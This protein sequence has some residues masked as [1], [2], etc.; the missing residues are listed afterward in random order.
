MWLRLLLY[1]IKCVDLLGDG[2]VLGRPTTADEIV[3]TLYIVKE[4][5]DG[6]K[7]RFQVRWSPDLFFD[8]EEAESNNDGN[9]KDAAEADELNQEA[10]EGEEESL[11][12]AAAPSR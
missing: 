4:T 7:P 9:D 5:E 2:N 12:A 8:V 1:D 3:G 11:R 10:P 6:S